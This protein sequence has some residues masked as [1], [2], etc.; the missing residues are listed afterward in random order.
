MSR[1]NLIKRSR[2][3]RNPSGSLWAGRRRRWGSGELVRQS[4]EAR[5]EAAASV[6]TTAAASTKAHAAWARIARAA[7][8][9]PGVPGARND[10][11]HIERAQIH[12]G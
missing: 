3:S 4:L 8:G 11:R 2:G 10:W 12:I 7:A 1:E 5:D 6:A 9:G